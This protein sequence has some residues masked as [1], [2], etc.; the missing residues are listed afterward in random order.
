MELDLSRYNHSTY[1]FLYLRV[2]DPDFNKKQTIDLQLRPCDDSLP[3]PQPIDLSPIIGVSLRELIDNRA[4]IFKMD[5]PPQYFIELVDEEKNVRESAW[6]NRLDKEHVWAQRQL[7]GE[8]TPGACSPP[9]RRMKR[10][11][12]LGVSALLL[13]SA[14]GLAYFNRE[15]IRAWGVAS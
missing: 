8:L 12:L 1:R 6:I 3:P 4:T 9:P 7:N 14:I 5:P 15:T 11:P 10:E 2:Q 13:L